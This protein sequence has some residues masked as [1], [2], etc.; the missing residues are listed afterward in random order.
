MVNRAD[1]S[2]TNTLKGMSTNLLPSPPTARAQRIEKFFHGVSLA[3]DY[4]W[5]REKDNPETVAYL[6]AENAY[7]EAFMAP[8]TSLREQ[9]YDEMLSHI[10]QTDVSVPYLDGAYW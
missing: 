9:L 6:E 10:K 3:D 8:L 5:L 4:A 1:G 2:A 7:A